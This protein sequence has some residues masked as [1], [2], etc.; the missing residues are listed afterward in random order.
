MS[1]VGK[2][3]SGA[4]LCFKKT[5]VSKIF[6]QKRVGVRVRIKG[7]HH[8]FAEIFL[9]HSAEKL[10]VANFWYGKKFMGKEGCGGAMV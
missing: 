5:L 6:T 2:I 9:S 3:R 4:P 8:G 7:L 1:H 10:P